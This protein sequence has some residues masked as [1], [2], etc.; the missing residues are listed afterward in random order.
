MLYE[1]TRGA[2]TLS[3]EHMEKPRPRGR[4]RKGPT[5]QKSYRLRKDLAMRLQLTSKLADLPE[6]VV[7]EDMLDKHCI[8]EESRNA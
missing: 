5:V 4:P 6:V 1:N 3:H 2:D 7:L 8:E